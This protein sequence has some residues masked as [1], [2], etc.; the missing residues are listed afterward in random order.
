MKTNI[1]IFKS[2]TV[3]SQKIFFIHKKLFNSMNFPLSNFPLDTRRFEFELLLSSKTKDVLFMT[4]KGL[5]PIYK[6][7]FRHL[8]TE[9]QLSTG[10]CCRDKGRSVF[11]LKRGFSV[12]KRG[13]HLPKLNLFSN[14]TRIEYFYSSNHY[15]RTNEYPLGSLNTIIIIF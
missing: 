5:K 4:C 2:R 7:E 1:K 11:N 15:L 6:R 8:S 10:K 12:R 13:Q 14:R 9:R 3:K